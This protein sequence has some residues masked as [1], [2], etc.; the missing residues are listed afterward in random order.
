MKT[1]GQ[2]PIT[3]HPFSRICPIFEAK[4]KRDGKVW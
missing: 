4:Q 2:N 1:D 3:T